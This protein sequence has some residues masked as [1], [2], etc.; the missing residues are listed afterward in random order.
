MKN[1][2]KLIA[3]AL[4]CLTLSSSIFIVGCKEKGPEYNC[5]TCQDEGV[6][7]CPN[8]HVKRCNYKSGGEE[9]RDGDIFSECDN[10][11]GYGY[12]GLQR[13]S[14]CG[15]DGYDSRG[16]KCTKCSSGYMKVDC[17][18]CSNGMMNTYKSCPICS[19]GL[20]GGNECG[21]CTVPYSTYINNGY[22]YIDCPDCL[23]D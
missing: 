19:W 12:I 3:I 14:T 5:N 7:D 8:C 11:D 1:L 15:G 16:Y 2:Q 9:C 17:P 13:C 21:Y 4:T 22:S 6:I 18:R 23:Q 10:C 20:V